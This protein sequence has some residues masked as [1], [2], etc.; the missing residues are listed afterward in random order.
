MARTFPNFLHNAP[1]FA[2]SSPSPTSLPPLPTASPPSKELS[3]SR[4]KPTPSLFPDYH[5]PEP[6]DTHKRPHPFSL[7][8]L[9][10]SSQDDHNLQQAPNPHAIQ[11]RTDSLPVHL[12]STHG[13][14]QIPAQPHARRH[15]K[16][17]PSSS[18]GAARPCGQ[19]R[20]EGRERRGTH[21]PHKAPQL[22]EAASARGLL[23]P[24]STPRYRHP[25]PPPRL[26]CG[27]G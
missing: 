24:S 10:H 20:P 12:H 15:R 17:T 23:V 5:S 19:H 16:V 18:A 3:Q 2:I 4:L 7:P 14:G 22:A 21:R 9:N 13:A 1:S 27:R 11:E 6:S 26:T 8:S 25:P